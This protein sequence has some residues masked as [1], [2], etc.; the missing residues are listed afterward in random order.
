MDSLTLKDG[1]QVYLSDIVRSMKGPEAM[2]ELMDDYCNIGMK[3]YSNGE[4]VGKLLQTHHRTIQASIIRFCMGVIIGLSKDARTDG[5]NK[6]PV[7]MGNQIADLVED[8]TLKM[9]WMI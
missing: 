6:M 3:D 5:R 9:G 2:A 1:T 4:A 7:A 8:G